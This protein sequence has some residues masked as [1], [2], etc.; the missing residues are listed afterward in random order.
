MRFIQYKKEI[1]SSAEGLEVYS[2]LSNVNNKKRLL[3]V[4]K[5][6]EV[7]TIYHTSCL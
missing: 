6:F 5:S 7:N 4:C 3:E 2:L 1:E